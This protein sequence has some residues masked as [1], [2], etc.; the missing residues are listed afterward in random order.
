[1][2]TT[3]ANRVPLLLAAFGALLL[4]ATF[5]QQFDGVPESWR[6]GFGSSSESSEGRDGGAKASRF[7]VCDSMIRAT[8]S[9]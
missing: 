4:L 2:I 1:M 7:V 9:C 5:F 6:V 3:Q 8:L